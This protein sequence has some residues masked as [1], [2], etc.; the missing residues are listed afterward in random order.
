MAKY[1][2]ELY[3]PKTGSDRVRDGAAR[4]RSAA[5][6]MAR[7]GKQIRYLRSIFVP[8]DETCFHLYDAGSAETVREASGRAGI[9]CERV[10]EAVNFEWR[11]ERKS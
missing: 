3:M 7:E 5:K 11:K 2:V 6:E 10:V 1:L 9:R 4:A 8:E